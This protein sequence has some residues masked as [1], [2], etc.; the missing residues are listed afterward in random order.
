MAVYVKIERRFWHDEKMVPLTGDGHLLALYLLT[1]PHGN[2]IGIFPLPAGYACADLNWTLEQFEAAFAEL[3]KPECGFA[4]YDPD[5]R[6]VWVVNHIRNNPIENQNQAKAGVGKLAELPRS[7][8]FAALAEYLTGLER[9]YLAVLVDGCRTH[10][11][12]P[13]AKPLGEPFPQRLGEPIPKPVSG[14][15]S[16]TVAGTGEGSPP[17]PPQGGKAPR[18]RPVFEEGTEPYRLARLLRDSIVDHLGEDARVP[19]PTPADLAPWAREFDAMIR[20]DGLAPPRI[21]EVLC[22]SRADPFW[23]GNILSPGKFRKQWTALVAKMARRQG[24]ARA[25]PAGRDLSAAEILQ[26]GEDLDSERGRSP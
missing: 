7:Q 15:G 22:W 13:L 23:Q 19:G 2:M 26:V 17:A 21:E 3:L 5:T 12:K 6:L 16:G 1:C 24:D 10:L 18:A 25:G 4:Q 14:S 11:P 20:L 9:P 8:L